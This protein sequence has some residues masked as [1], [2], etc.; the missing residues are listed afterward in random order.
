[1]GFCQRQYGNV[2]ACWIEDGYVCQEMACTHVVHRYP[3]QLDVNIPKQTN[4][5]FS[6]TVA[7]LLYHEDRMYVGRYDGWISIYRVS[8][9]MLV[10]IN[11]WTPDSNAICMQVGFF[12]DNLIVYEV[13]LDVRDRQTIYSR[14]HR[15][16]AK[17][18]KQ[19]PAEVP[20][21]FDAK[22]FTPG[23]PIE[24][25][26]LLVGGGEVVGVDVWSVQDSL[27]RQDCRVF[28]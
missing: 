1:M 18:K 20:A 9:N 11:R 12:C 28:L 25:W 10:G 3:T 27:W 21:L 7:F 22:S 23:T 13:Y 24:D 5:F 14:W 2:H 19:I 16:E 8:D 26:Y 4:I 17:L 15:V 6:F